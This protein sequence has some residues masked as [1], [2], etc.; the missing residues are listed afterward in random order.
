MHVFVFFKQKTAY[1]MRIS[2]WSSDVCASDLG[3][4]D[5]ADRDE[6]P[7]VARLGQIGSRRVEQPPRRLGDAREARY[8]ALVVDVAEPA[9]RNVRG[10][11]DD[12]VDPAERPRRRLDQRAAVG[13]PRDIAGEESGVPATIGRAHD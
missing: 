6:A 7:A 2:D 13:V 11:M 3:A 9:V 5:R 10:G 1:E 8:E 4:V 12:D